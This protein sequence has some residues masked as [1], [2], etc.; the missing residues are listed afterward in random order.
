MTILAECPLSGG[1][2]TFNYMKKAHYVGSGWDERFAFSLATASLRVGLTRAC[3]AR[4]AGA[5][6]AS[7]AQQSC[8]RL[9][10]R[11]RRRVLNRD[12]VAARVEQGSKSHTAL[13]KKNKRPQKG[14]LIFLAERV[15]FEPTKGYKPLLVFKTSAFDHSATSPV[16]GRATAHFART[17][18]RIQYTPALK[19]RACSPYLPITTKQL[20]EP[21]PTVRV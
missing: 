18:S 19:N 21:L 4:P 16:S 10:L 7:V 11:L 2:R 5:L 15:G 1:K 3:S 20:C 9:T 12:C 13:G 8:A 17:G 14:P 6:R